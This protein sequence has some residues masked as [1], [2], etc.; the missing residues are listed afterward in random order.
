MHPALCGCIASSDLEVRQLIPRVLLG[1]HGRVGAPVSLECSDSE[2]RRGW[3]LPQKKTTC[4]HE[5]YCDRYSSAAVVRYSNSRTTC[6]SWIFR[7]WSPHRFLQRRDGGT[8]P[9]RARRARRERHRAQVLWIGAQCDDRHL[10]PQPHGVCHSIRIRSPIAPV[11]AA[12]GV[13]VRGVQPPHHASI[14][15]SSWPPLPT[16]ARSCRRSPMPSQSDQRS[17]RHPL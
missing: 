8:I 17:G 10:R 4:T 14:R 3:P 16:S 11:A 13:S 5:R 6:T 7:L 1:A 9:M 15:P 2:V 12:G